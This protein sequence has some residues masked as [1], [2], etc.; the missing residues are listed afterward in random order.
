MLC[1]LSSVLAQ[2]K[3]SQASEQTV[4]CVS[5]SSIAS[6]ATLH[7]SD[8]SVLESSYFSSFLLFWK[9]G[10]I[11]TEVLLTVNVHN[12]TIFFNT[13]P[14]SIFLWI[15]LNF[16]PF[17]SH[18]V[19]FFV[20]FP[21]LQLFQSWNRASLPCLCLCVTTQ[22]HRMAPDSAIKEQRGL[23]ICPRLQLL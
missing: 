18:I 13:I 5:Y 1:F 17:I 11:W 21:S 22:I 8:N 15:S 16:F 9:W 23:E 20:L 6:F 19:P 4:P 12:K 2:C 14:L 3:Q 7:L 10:I